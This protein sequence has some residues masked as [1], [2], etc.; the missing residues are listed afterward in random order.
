MVF[1]GFFARHEFVYGAEEV[2]AEFKA[3]ARTDRLPRVCIVAEHAS[4]RFGGE[5]IL[6]VHY[7]RLLRQRGA[8][9]HLVVHERTRA[10]LDVL[11]PDETDR[12]HYIPDL[13][14]HKLLFRLSTLLPR[15]ISE[16]SFGLLIQ[17]VTQF[18]QRS[19]VRGLVNEAKIDLVHQPI[20]VAPR[21]PSAMSGLHV[22]VV[23]GPLNGGMDY[24]AAFRSSESAWSRAAVN[25][26]RV[27]ANIGNRLIPG[28]L[29]A[30]A[31]LVANERTREALPEGIQGA[32]I[33]VVENGIDL[34]LWHDINDHDLSGPP[35]FVFMGRLVDW[36]A[37]DVVLEAVARVPQVELDVI[38]DGPMRAAWTALA[39][40]LGIADRIHFLGWQQQ[41]ACAERMKSA[42]ALV[43]P[44]VYECGGAV[45]LE[46]MAMARPVIAT[47][48]GGPADYLDAHCGILVEPT[49]REAMIDGFA[50]AMQQLNEDR[51]LAQ[52]LGQNGKRR[53][54]DLFDWNRKIDR[55]L[56]IYR[57]ALDDFE[58]CSTD[59]GK[60][61]GQLRSAQSVPRQ[62]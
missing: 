7:F 29:Q 2:T 30:S 62:S 52:Q 5:A 49:S 28:K 23:I 60:L 15:R 26:A 22:P 53:A 1:T 37:L 61:D 17:L 4:T 44:S 51:A 50:Q 54:Q 43:L 6:P 13:W 31:V 35:R 56:E 36:K 8:D 55:I 11:F 46:A 58:R 48:W 34:N 25:F 39:G 33:D 59:A 41:Q 40:K 45:V 38:G 57:A 3:A 21:F 24:P 47:N 32:V 16:A 20:P 12:I 10:E 27:F 19:V 18:C 9:C 42:L 14:I